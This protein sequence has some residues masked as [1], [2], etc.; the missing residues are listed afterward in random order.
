[1]LDQVRLACA[2]RVPVLLV[3]EPGS[4]KQ[5][6]ARTIH[7]QGSRRESAFVALDC[8]RLPAAVVAAAL[9]GERRPAVTRGTY[10]LREFACLSHDLQSWLRDRLRGAEEIVGPRW[11]ASCS[12]DPV[13]EVR[14]GRLL[15]EL[16][17]AF[18]TLIITVPPL[19]ERLA[20]L[21]ALVERFL[22]RAN[23]DIERRVTGLTREAWDLLHGYSWPGNL[24]ELYAVLRSACRRT[25][26]EYIDAGHLPASL[27]LAARLDRT[28]LA[29]ADMPL[30]MQEIL[31]KAERRLILLALRKAQGNHTRAAE[32]LSIW[33]PRLLRRI[34]ALGIKEAFPGGH[35]DRDKNGP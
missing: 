14:A 32:I 25:L 13:E 12:V 19:R 15:E 29:M 5:W 2:T 11:T 33:R 18:G 21:P 17:A 27:R 9:F 7:Y 20:D 3:G 26:S 34:K 16:Y 6:I 30:P 23:A 10:Y 28:P 35:L 24:R 8:A 4:G 31:E 1:M 22:E